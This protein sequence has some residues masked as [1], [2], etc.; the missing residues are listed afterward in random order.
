MISQYGHTALHYSTSDRN[1]ETMQ[2][3]INKGA[4]VNSRSHVVA[5]A[6]IIKVLE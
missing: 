2:L 4:D 1:S 3:L 5:F 6:S